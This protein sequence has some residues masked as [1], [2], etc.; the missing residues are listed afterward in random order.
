MR[1]EE[2]RDTVA[3]KSALQALA[4]QEEIQDAALWYA[5][6]Q[7]AHQPGCPGT[8]IRGEC[9]CGYTQWKQRLHKMLLRGEQQA[10]RGHT[11]KNVGDKQDAQ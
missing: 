11:Q 1:E 9:L 5:L 10:I 2:F 6:S 7:A 4:E 8:N 3:D